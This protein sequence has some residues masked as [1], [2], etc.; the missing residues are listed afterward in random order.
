M[1]LPQRHTHHPGLAGLAAPRRI[2]VLL[3]RQSV[4]APGRSDT[5]RI[6]D[7]V[8]HC[9]SAC[10]CLPEAGTVR[11]R[12]ARSQPSRG[13]RTPG[14]LTPLRRVALA[15][16]ASTASRSCRGGLEHSRRWPSALSDRNNPP[17]QLP[18]ALSLRKTRASLRMSCLHPRAGLAGQRRR[19]DISSPDQVVRNHEVLVWIVFAGS[20]RVRYR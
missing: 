3:K 15:N 2:A 18:R 1:G 19:G 6:D 14:K 17:G 5:A 10:P 16:A 20:F 9:R 12:Q 4:I 7:R 13:S 8:R 11:A